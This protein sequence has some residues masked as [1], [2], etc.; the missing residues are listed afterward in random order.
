MNIAEYN[1]NAWNL[2]SEEGCRWST[3]YPDEVFE[4]ARAGEWSV[5]LT[6]NKAVP[7]DWFPSYPD[8][9]GVK[10]LALACGGGQQV[11]IFAAAGAE[12]TSYD[13]SDVQLEKDVETCERHGLEFRAIQGDMADMAALSDEEFD[14]IFNPVSNVFAENLEPIW[15]ESTRVMKK[16]GSL[17][18]GFMETAFFI[19]EHEV[20]E[21]TGL[22]VDQVHYFGSQSWPFPNSLM[23]GFRARYASGD[24]KLEDPEV[25][26]A[27]WFRAGD[28]PSIFPGNLSISQWLI[29]DFLKRCR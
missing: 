28:M 9:S 18:C 29:D 7:A 14:L 11:P 23:L 22:E 6:P 25:E 13:A 17:L 27:G 5:I 19:F 10:V 16:G 3:P 26:E 2:Q 24:I 12:V 4:K 20:L 21:E 15:Q 8:L 1:R